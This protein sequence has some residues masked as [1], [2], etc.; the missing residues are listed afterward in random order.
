MTKKV[1]AREKILLAAKK[2]FM[3]EGFAGAAISKIAALAEVPHSLI[4]HHFKNKETLW[5]EVKQ[6]IVKEATHRTRT[7]P[8]THLPFKIFLQK[9]FTQNIKFYRQ[10]PDI[11][12]M[13]NWQRVERATSQK[14]G[15]T[16]SDETKQW[17]MAFKHYQQKGE[18]NPKLKTEFILTLALSIISTAAL[19]PNIFIKQSKKEKD[20]VDF[21]VKSLLKALSA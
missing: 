3:K 10:N 1:S 5:I 18:I 13:I 4:F 11:I 16:R 15:I 19:D 17:L 7:L 8:D 9:L 12:Q 20:Y 2:V 6:H 14:I 21:C